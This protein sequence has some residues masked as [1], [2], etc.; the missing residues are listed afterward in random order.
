MTVERRQ[1]DVRS[2]VVM[3]ACPFCGERLR[4]QQGFENHWAS[5]PENPR[6][7]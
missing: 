5:C 7:Q 4:E 6:N 3:T 1:Y 2:S